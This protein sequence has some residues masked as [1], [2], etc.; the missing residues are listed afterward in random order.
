MMKKGFPPNQGETFPRSAFG[1]KARLYD[2]N[3]MDSFWTHDFCL[4]PRGYDVVSFQSILEAH[5]LCA[6][7]DP[8]VGFVPLPTERNCSLAT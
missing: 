2:D 1:F 6:L 7:I 8:N 5:I 4:F 3:P